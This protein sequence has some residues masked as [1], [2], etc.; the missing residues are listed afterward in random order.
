[1]PS[2]GGLVGPY[3]Q[4]Q[5]AGTRPAPTVAA[6]FVDSG[7]ARRP[8]TLASCPQRAGDKL[9]LRTHGGISQGGV[10]GG[11]PRT[12]EGRNGPTVQGQWI[13]ISG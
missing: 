4:R 5:R 10:A 1:M 3:C 7:A 6:A 2:A 12:R 11:V 8:H 9:E 13:V